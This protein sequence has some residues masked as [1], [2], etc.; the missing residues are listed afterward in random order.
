MAG[1]GQAGLGPE[2]RP[3]ALLVFLKYPVSTLGSRRVLLDHVIA[4][5]P[6]RGP[7]RGPVLG[8]V[9]GPV[10]SPVLAPVH[11]IDPIT[12]NIESILAIRLPVLAMPGTHGK[13]EDTRQHEQERKT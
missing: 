11:P 7:V 4:V 9:L 6:I 10:R 5:D 13:T 3:V 1:K 12:W 2:L 8:P